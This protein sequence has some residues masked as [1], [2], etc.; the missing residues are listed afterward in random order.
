MMSVSAFSQTPIIRKAIIDGQN[1]FEANAVFM[2]LIMEEH[3]RFARSLITNDSLQITIEFLNKKL[4]RV[5]LQVDY[6]IQDNTRLEIQ[7]STLSKQ[8]ENK[9]EQHAI[10]LLYYKEKSKGK[11]NS[12]LFGTAAGGLIV[13]IIA[14]VSK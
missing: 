12:F 9:D 13:A 11:L 10:D 2:D 5:N 7:K 3:Y 1:G 8:L 14:I 4:E 6:L